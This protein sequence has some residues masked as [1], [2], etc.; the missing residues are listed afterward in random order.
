VPCA[1]DDLTPTAVQIEAVEGTPPTPGGG[2][3]LDGI[4]DVTSYLLYGPEDA[5]AGLDGGGSFRGTLR[6][7]DSARGID[8]VKTSG[9]GTDVVGY[10]LASDGTNLDLTATCPEQLVGLEASAGFT[11]TGDTVALH[12][13]QGAP[14]VVTY[15]KRSVGSP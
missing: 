6:I 10:A 11:A 12:F 1:F 2:V 14:A 7:R 15:T 3:L 8:I 4:Y 9:P 13:A 5:L